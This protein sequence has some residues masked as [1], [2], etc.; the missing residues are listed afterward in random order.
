MSDIIPK[1]VALFERLPG[2]GPRQARRFVYA[3]LDMDENIVRE[4]ADSILQLR[5]ETWRCP[6]CFRAHN[7]KGSACT[8][9]SIHADS[10]P[11]LVVER[12]VDLEN[13]EN[14]GI[15]DGLTFILG[16]TVSSLGLD[17]KSIRLH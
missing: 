8:L 1:L 10:S 16:G 7:G 6:E 13:L 11:L 17:T 3:L 12:G 4:F 15:Y 9:C 14:L 5:A 2:I